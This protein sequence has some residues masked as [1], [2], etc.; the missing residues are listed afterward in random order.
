MTT[1]R[2][3]TAD[4][5]R[6]GGAVPADAS[7]LGVPMRNVVMESFTPVVAAAAAIAASQTVTGAGTA[8]VINGSLALGTP[9]TVTFDTPRNV[10]AAWTNTAIITITGKDK[11]GCPM[12]EVSASG[13]SHTGAKAFKSVSSITTNATI[14]SA[15]AGSGAVLGLSYRPKVGGFIRGIL[16]ENTADA[17]TYA[18]PIRTTSTGTTADV[19]GTYAYAGT[20]NG[21]NVFTVIYVAD[22][23]P[24]RL[25]AFGIN[26]FAG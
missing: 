20:A 17:G 16:N 2:I 15:T 21:T 23:G 9:P 8:F 5:V 6:S 11:Y 10:V 3:T 26:Q 18:A 13:T 7:L 12:V 25:N 14:T 1:H 22:N 24:E 19:R 4:D